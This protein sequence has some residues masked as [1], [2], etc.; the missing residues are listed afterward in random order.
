MLDTAYPDFQLRM[1]LSPIVHGGGGRK[2]N[3][4]GT[5]GSAHFLLSN[6]C[7]NIK[8]SRRKIKQIIDVWKEKD[9]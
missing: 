2:R 3:K 5:V 1:E 6:Y 7:S 9:K 4:R 8:N